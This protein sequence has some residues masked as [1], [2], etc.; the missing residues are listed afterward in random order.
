MRRSEGEFLLPKT[1]QRAFSLPVAHSAK[2]VSKKSL[3]GNVTEFDH[4]N[5]LTFHGV[6]L[7]AIT[8]GISFRVHECGALV[9]TSQDWHFNQV[10]SPFWR[11]YYDGLPGCAIVSQGRRV[12]LGP[13]RAVIIPEQVTFDCASRAG[14][15]HLWLHFSIDSALSAPAKSPLVIE[16]TAAMQAAFRN[17][18]KAIDDGSSGH[19]LVH[20]CAGTLHLCLAQ[21]VG[22]IVALPTSGRMRLLLD[23]IDNSLSHELSNEAMAAKSSLST[24]AFLRWF[25]KES[26]LT[27]A[28]YV[29]KRRVREACRQLAFTDATIEEIAENLRYADR[30]HFSRAFKRHMGFGPA[31]FRRMTQ[32]AVEKPGLL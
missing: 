18:R 17:L 25:R 23:F 21:L 5:P 28:A 13:T 12:P 9:H 2:N 4:A 11:L 14:V 32:Q 27:P 16:L 6:R 19:S 24:G 29:S 10:V 20:L 8:A 7:P 22:H 31:S 3:V 30:H 15:P 1:E 26:G